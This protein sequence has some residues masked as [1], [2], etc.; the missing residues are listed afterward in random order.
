MIFVL[1]PC[2]DRPLLQFI[3]MKIPALLC[4]AKS[5][6]HAHPVGKIL[7]TLQVFLGIVQLMTVHKTNGI[8]Y[9]V[10]MHVI[11]VNMHTYQTL[12]SGKPLSRKLFP[13]LQRLLWCDWLVLMP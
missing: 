3:P 11:P 8:G 12:E 4:H 5:T 10:A 7:H 9:N 6:L 13:K 1:A 2:T